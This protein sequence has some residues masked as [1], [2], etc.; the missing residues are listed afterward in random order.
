VLEHTDDGST[1]EV[2]ID[3][4]FVAVGHQPNSHLVEGQVKTDENG[5]VQVEGRSTRTGV[6]GVFAA[7]DLVDHTYRQAVTAAGSGCMAALDAEVYLRDTPLD[8][9]AHWAPD[10]DKLEQRAAEAAASTSP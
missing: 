5:Y 2:E 6:P 3:G 4:A 1:K 8:A 7:G 9:E 10:V